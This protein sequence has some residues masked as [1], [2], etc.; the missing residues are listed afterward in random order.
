MEKRQLSYNMKTK[1]YYDAIPLHLDPQS[2]KISLARNAGKEIDT[3][4]VS[5]ADRN[6]NKSGFCESFSNQ[7]V[8]GEVS[9]N[10]TI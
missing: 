10:L 7:A 9:Q 2:L 6:I 4:S 1:L 3:E 8:S 5:F